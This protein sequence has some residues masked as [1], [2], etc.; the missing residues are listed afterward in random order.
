MRLFRAYSQ[1]V[2]FATCR[3]WIY[4]NEVQLKSSECTA[5]S[6]VGCIPGCRRNAHLPRQKRP[7]FAEKAKNGRPA[8][9][10]SGFR[11]RGRYFLQLSLTMLTLVT[12]RWPC[13][14]E[15]LS[16]PC[17]FISSLTFSLAP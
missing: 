8:F 4:R 1:E 14:V 2:S 15:S 10:L 11:D 16:T 7:R 17:S 3:A 5:G 9:S 6:V 13:S 12:L